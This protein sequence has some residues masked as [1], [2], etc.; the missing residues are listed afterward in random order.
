MSR[1]T[2]KDEILGIR[3][4]GGSSQ[5]C[6]WE[7]PSGKVLMDKWSQ[8]RKAG[9]LQVRHLLARAAAAVN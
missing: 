1:Q 4:R 2:V 9:R 5:H 3:L 7:P 8:A 6:L